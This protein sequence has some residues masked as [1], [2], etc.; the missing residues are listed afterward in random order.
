MEPEINVSGSVEPPPSGLEST[1]D[2]NIAA[3]MSPTVHGD[4]L[5]YCVGMTFVAGALTGMIIYSAFSKY[6]DR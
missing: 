3:A 2:P 4:N 6:G 5:L 1:T